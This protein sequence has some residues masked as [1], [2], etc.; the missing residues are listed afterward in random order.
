L[1]CNRNFPSLPL[2]INVTVNIYFVPQ[3]YKA[4]TWVMPQKRNF[5]ITCSFD[6]KLGGNVSPDLGDKIHFKS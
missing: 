3:G 6:L 1:K 4:R 2:K 5:M